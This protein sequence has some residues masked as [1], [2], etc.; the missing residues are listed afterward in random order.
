MKME[1]AAARRSAL[2]L[3]FG[4]DSQAGRGVFIMKNR[5]G[6]PCPLLEVAGLGWLSRGE[7]SCGTDV[8]SLSIFDWLLLY[9]KQGKN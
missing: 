3:V 2:S 7:T 6:V 8:G 5:E 4:R 1:R 9:W